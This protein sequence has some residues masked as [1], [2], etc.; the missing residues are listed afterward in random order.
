MPMRVAAVECLREASMNKSL[1]L[2]A[3]LVLLLPACERQPAERHH[4]PGSETDGAAQSLEGRLLAPCCWNQTLDVHE[5]PV[6]TE[7]RGE[8]ASRLA[9]GE[10]ASTIEDDLA[11]RYGE[12]IRVVP[13][14]SDPRNVMPFI[15]G[16]GMLLSALG[17]TLLLRSWLRRSRRL[18]AQSSATAPNAAH[19]ARAGDATSA[20]PDAYDRRLDD[21]LAQMAD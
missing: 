4:D 5:S 3:L 20:E 21:E 6:A 2:L 17:L 8:I 14:G 18:D 7:L 12:R 10:P 1:P 13:R 15:V 11:A 19:E 16:G 9:N